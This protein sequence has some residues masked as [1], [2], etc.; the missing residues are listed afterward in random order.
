MMFPFSS[1]PYRRYTYPSRYLSYAPRRPLENFDNLYK[2]K[3]EYNTVTEKKEESS[4]M[5]ISDSNSDK[6][7]RSYNNTDDSFFELFGI[8]LYF[9]DILLI[10]MIFFLYSEGVEDQMLF[11]ALILLLL[12]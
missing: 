1:F 12:S 10:C 5:I 7:S 2:E 3:T 6:G 4:S 8:K 11:I 9:D